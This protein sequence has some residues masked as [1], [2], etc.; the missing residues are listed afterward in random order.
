MKIPPKKLVIYQ[1]KDGAI[2][3]R[4]N[5]EHEESV[6]WG[7]LNQIAQ[8]FGRDKSVISRHIRNIFK[9]GELDKVATVAKIATVQ[10][11]GKRKVTREI[12]YYNLDVILSVGYRVDSKVA[13]A[14]RKWA[15]KTLK[16]HL[17]KGYTINKKTLKHNYQEFLRAVEDIKFLVK[18]NRK[19]GADDVLKL[20]KSFSATWFNL[21]SQIKSTA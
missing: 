21:E 16:Q 6:V 17:I 20:I 10:K 9:S 1:S 7:S 19:V 18:D 2:A 3:F 13:I 15:T 12:E 8:L 4:G 14:F 11:E 5:F